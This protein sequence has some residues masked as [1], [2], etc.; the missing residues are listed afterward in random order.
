VATYKLTTGSG[1]RVSVADNG[2]SFIV[3]KTIDFSETAYLATDVLEAIVVPDKHMVTL[4]QYEVETVEGAVLTFD[5]GDGVTTDGYLVGVN[6]NVIGSVATALVLVDG[7]PNTVL[8]YS[9]GKYYAANDSIDVT[10]NNNA[11]VGKIHVRAV[12][13]DLSR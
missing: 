10:L 1:K 12:I 13:L 4:V 2:G 7:T 8:G 6:G 11:S 3:E 9:N 5:I